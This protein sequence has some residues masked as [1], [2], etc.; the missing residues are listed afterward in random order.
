MFHR[1]V[2]GLGGVPVPGGCLLWGGCLL[3]GLW[4]QGV[5]LLPGRGGG[6]ACSRREGVWPQGVPGGDPPDGYCSGQYASYWNAFLL[7]LSFK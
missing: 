1:G 6:G 5:C 2:P 7:L 4:S 3:Q